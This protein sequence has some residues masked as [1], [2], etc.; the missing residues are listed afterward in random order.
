MYL[1]EAVTFRGLSAFSQ[2]HPSETEGADLIF[3]DDIYEDVQLQY[4][5]TA[6][7]CVKEGRCHSLF[8]AYISNYFINTQ[9]FIYYQ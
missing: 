7:N 4:Y 1:I 6:R 5:S 2:V 8:S 3:S 9:H